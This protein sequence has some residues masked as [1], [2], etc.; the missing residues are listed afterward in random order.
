M[1]RASG[2]THRV[3]RICPGGTGAFGGAGSGG[4]AGGAGIPGG[5]GVNGGRG[6]GG[7]PGGGAAT[8]GSPGGGG[9]PAGGVAAVTP[10]IT[11]DFYVISGLGSST[12]I[13]ERHIPVAFTITLDSHS[14][15]LVNSDYQVTV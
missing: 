3:F 14:E 15:F 9:G 5:G 8:G 11:V 1:R 6:P 2:H 12:L 7:T 4:V 13:P 10:P